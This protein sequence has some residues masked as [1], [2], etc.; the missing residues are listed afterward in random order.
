MLTAAVITLLGTAMRQ[1]SAA[2][3]TRIEPQLI[4]QCQC[5]VLTRIP[6]LPICMQAGLACE[7]WFKRQRSKGVS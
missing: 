1:Y 6:S 3:D 7:K 4:M 5:I 2:S